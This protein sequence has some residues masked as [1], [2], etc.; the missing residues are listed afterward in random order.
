MSGRRISVKKKKQITST[1]KKQKTITVAYAYELFSIYQRE[2]GNS[3]STIQFYDR[4][5]KK[6]ALITDNG[7]QPVSV[8]TET[9]F[10][11]RFIQSL[12]NVNRQTI[13]A[14]LRGY[15][16]FGNYCKQKG[17]IDEFS[18]PIKETEPPIKQVY[19]KKELNAL[20]KKPDIEDFVAFRSYI[21]ILLFLSTGARANTVLNIRISDIDFDE[22]YIAFNTTKAHKVV[23]IGLSKKLKKELKEY[24]NYWR[25]GEDVSPDD[26]LICN[27]YGE[28]MSRCA[29][30]VSIAKY[31]KSCG[32][33]KTSLHLFRH[34]FAKNW[35]TSGGD[36]ISL[37][38]VLT[39]SE[40]E[41]VKRYANLYSSDITEKIEK[42][43]TLSQLNSSCDKTL[44]SKKNNKKK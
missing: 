34:T 30:N 4:A 35:I 39:H 41:M 10:Q 3:E 13:N 33:E 22:G 31:N 21:V 29:L 40:L 38:K 24:I 28:K 16:S 32:V 27:V 25:T 44:K 37:A 20:I 36:L 2:K 1:K 6:L 11:E 8:F 5:Y 43:S 23:Q 26:Y 15:R 14:Y 9:G 18:C 12:G 17:F 42:H 7:T 19:T